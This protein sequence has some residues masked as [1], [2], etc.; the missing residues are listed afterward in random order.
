MSINIA[1]IFQSFTH[2]YIIAINLSKEKDMYIVDLRPVLRPKE[3]K[4]EK[5]AYK[6]SA[7]P[8]SFFFL[9]NKVV[10]MEA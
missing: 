8:W 2:C 4:L 10:G 3:C 9:Y 5:H 7:P 1:L 6:G